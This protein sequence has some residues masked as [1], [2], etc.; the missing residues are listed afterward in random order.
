M[1]QYEDRVE[2]ARNAERERRDGW[3]FKYREY[4]YPT[5]KWGFNNEVEVIIRLDGE[6]NKI[7]LPEGAT[8]E[9]REGAHSFLKEELR[10][11]KKA[12]A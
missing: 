3:N 9:T 5:L 12:K 1:T 4:N 8:A 7:L 6:P 11:R 10:L 2:R